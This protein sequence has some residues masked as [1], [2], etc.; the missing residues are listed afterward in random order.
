MKKIFTAMILIIIFALPVYGAVSEDLSVYL[1]NDV[2]EA[3]ME[4]FIAEI[5][6][7]NEQLRREM[8][9]EIKSLRS[10]IQDLQNKTQNLYSEIRVIN[11][12]LDD[13][14]TAI[15]WGLAFMGI[16]LASAIFVPGIVAVF[17]NLFS[18]SI[19]MEQVERLI[20][21]KLENR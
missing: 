1:R 18:P 17:K 20:N 19:T 14:T 16:I 10:E 5:R 8:Q 3:K 9:D 15:Y 21:A 4:A 11:T 12:R 6:L 7:M 2:F 13:L